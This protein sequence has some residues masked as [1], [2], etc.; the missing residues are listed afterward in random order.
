MA[1]KRSTIWMAPGNCSS[2]RF[3][4]H[5]APSPRTTPRSAYE[6]LKR[7]SAELEEKVREATSE[8]VRQNELLRRQ[9]IQLD[10]LR[11]PLNAILG[12]A[13]LLLRGV[14][15][16]LTEEQRSTVSRLD[17]NGRHLLAL[18]NDVLDIS[19]IEAGKMPLTL[20]EVVL[21]ELIAEVMEEVEPLIDRA[22]L[23]VTTDVARQLP[24]VRSDRQKIKQIV[25]NLLTNALK[26][27]PQGSVRVSCTYSKA[28][29]DIALAVAD[30]G[31]EIAPADQARI[32]DDFSQAD[33]STS[34]GY[35]G[36]GLGLSISRR[37]AD[38][39]GGRLT[40]ESKVGQGSTFTLRLPVRPR[41]NL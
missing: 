18:I 15:G 6:R 14:S 7:A 10:E 4:I 36:A 37:L 9:S 17:A 16:R 40:V 1:W 33:T 19:R 35:T 32:F 12:Y 20:G 21:A 5:G 26:F 24:L 28:T 34:R 38:V 27:T 25:L 11:T 30:T 8:L 3:Q 13:S 39:I 22:R 29:R 41:R 2:A 31:I 23:V